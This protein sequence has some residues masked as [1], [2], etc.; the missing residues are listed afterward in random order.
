MARTKQPPPSPKR[1]KHLPSTPKRIQFAHDAVANGRAGGGPKISIREASERFQ[2]ARSTLS[3]R[4][5]GKHSSAPAA[6]SDQSLLSLDQEAVVVE[7]CQHKLKRAQPLTKLTLHSYVYSLTGKMPGRNWFWRF[8]KR[9]N[10]DLFFGNASG[11]DPARAQAFNRA[12]VKRHFD[13]VAAQKQ[14]KHYDP[15]CDWNL[16]EQGC[17]FGGGR[18]TNERKV[19]LSRHSRARARLANDDLEIVTIIEAVNAAGD[20][21]APGFVFQGKKLRKSWF[22]ETDIGPARCVSS[23]FSFSVHY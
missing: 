9:H 20:A 8:M 16:D 6:H 14:L 17:T 3:D 7:W 11:R 18:V 13:A 22:Q 1:P 10:D 23:V 15:D 2:V 19:I 21:M 5:T 12:N 4:L